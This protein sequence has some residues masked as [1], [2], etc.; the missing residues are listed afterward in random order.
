MEKTKVIMHINSY[1]KGYLILYISDMG[2][3]SRLKSLTEVCNKKHGGYVK[4]EMSPP[5]KPRTTSVHGQNRHIHGHLQ[6]IA[7][8]TGYELED[9]KDYIKQRAVRR[10]YP[11]KQNPLTGEIKPIPSRFA[12]TVEASYLIEEL[13]QLAAEMDIP[14]NEGE[15]E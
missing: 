15:Y 13:H 3:Q 2:V 1:H 4:L 6:D 11:T 14:L 12:N 7:D 5:Y 8:Y 10:G 9:I